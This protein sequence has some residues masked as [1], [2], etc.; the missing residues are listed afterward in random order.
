MPIDSAKRSLQQLLVSGHVDYAYLGL[1]TEDLT[2]A[3]AK[4]FRLPGRARRDREL[5]RQG[6]PAAAAGPARRHTH[7]RLA[8]PAR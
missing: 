8:E 1:E 2:P 5:G 7:R 6:G 4:A 3:I